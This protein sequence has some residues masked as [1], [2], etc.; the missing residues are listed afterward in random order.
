MAE[1]V[2]AHI[3]AAIVLEIRY[4]QVTDQVQEDRHAEQQQG[5]QHRPGRVLME[6][7]D[8]EPADDVPDEGQRDPAAVH[9]VEAH[10]IARFDQLAHA[11]H[12][13][14]HAEARDNRVQGQQEFENRHAVVGPRVPQCRAV[15]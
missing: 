12:E 15:T 9:P 8:R 3:V 14:R 5:L 2:V 6:A 13:Q 7:P 4:G 10:A 11:G 1:V